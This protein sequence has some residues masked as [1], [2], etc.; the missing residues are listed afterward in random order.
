[1]P[2]AVREKVLTVTMQRKTIWTLAVGGCGAVLILL[3]GLLGWVGF[4]A[5]VES[6]VADVSF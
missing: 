3:G 5:I 6:T 1:M 4:P 2:K